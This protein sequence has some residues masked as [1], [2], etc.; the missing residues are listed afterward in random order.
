MSWQRKYDF[1]PGTKISSSQVDEEFNQLIDI[2][3]FLETSVNERARIEQ[4]NLVPL[5]L[6]NG[7]VRQG[8]NDYPPA[9]RK[10]DTNYVYVVGAITKST[11]ILSSTVIAVLPVGSRPAYNFV[12]PITC[13][14]ADAQIWTQST[15]SVRSNGNIIADIVPNG[16]RF[17]YMNMPPFLAEL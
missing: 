17:I 5:V 7:F 13:V 15:G 16:T 6:Q 9:Y 10:T 3:N 11:D 4:G 8:T 2:A 12:V 1:Q 14:S